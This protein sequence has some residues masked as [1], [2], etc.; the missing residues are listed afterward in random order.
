M[1]GN[2][3]IGT[4]S[5]A[6]NNEPCVPWNETEHLWEYNFNFPINPNGNE[7]YCRN[8]NHNLN[9]PWCYVQNGASFSPMQ[10]DVPFCGKLYHSSISDNYEISILYFQVH[11]RSLNQSNL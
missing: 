2:T 5:K 7:A 8:P 1:K 11:S 4:I 3:Y 9:G 6:I 10:C